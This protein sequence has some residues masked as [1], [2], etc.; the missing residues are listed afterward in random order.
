MRNSP[1]VALDIEAN[2]DDTAAIHE[3]Q[4]PAND[5]LCTTT[6]LLEEIKTTRKHTYV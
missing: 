2:F 3:L 6:N 5:E 1:V 4:V